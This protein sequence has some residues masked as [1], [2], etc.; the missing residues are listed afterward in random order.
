MKNTITMGNDEFILYIRKNYNCSL[1]N[2]RIGRMTQKWILENSK[3]I[4]KDKDI[5]RG[6]PCL[7]QSSRMRKTYGMRLPRT[8]S[9]I[10]FNRKLLPKLYTFLDEVGEKFSTDELWSDLIRKKLD[11]DEA[12]MPK[13]NF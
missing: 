12:L 10:T 1:T 2:D 3:G 13:L 8:A 6:V 7:W 11:A 5:V 9:Q 4:N